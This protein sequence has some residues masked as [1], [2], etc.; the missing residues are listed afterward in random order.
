M[1]LLLPPLVVAEIGCLDHPGTVDFLYFVLSVSIGLLTPKYWFFL[2]P[3]YALSLSCALSQA[4]PE[5]FLVDGIGSDHKFIVFLSFLI[6]LAGVNLAEVSLECSLM[7]VFHL[8]LGLH[9]VLPCST[10]APCYHFE[11]V[12]DQF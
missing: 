3:G 11:N 2:V 12:L 9:P 10:V 8:D 1:S 7:P 4:N 6:S 5:P